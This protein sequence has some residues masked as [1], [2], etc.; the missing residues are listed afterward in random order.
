MYSPLA[1]PHAT[2]AVLDAHGLSTKYRLG[3]NFLI[4]DNVIGRILDLA[5]PQP[6]DVLLEV[7]PGIGTLTVALLSTGASVVAIECDSDLPAVLADTVPANAPFA[8]IQGDAVTVPHAAVCE[9]FGPPVALVS[10]LPYAVAA[11]VVLRYFEEFE[12]L[13]SATVMVQTEVAQRMAATP[14]SKI[15]GAYT[16]KLNL[17]AQAVSSFKVAPNSFFPPPRVSST[18]LRLERAPIVSS[19]AEYQ[20]VAHVIDAS[21]AQ[22]RKTLRNNLKQAFD[23]SSERVDA[24]CAAAGLDG[25][26][27]AETLNAQE[28]IALTEALEGALLF[29]LY[30][31]CFH[32]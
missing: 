21:F 30:P 2:R 20:R 3:Q 26:L 24:A 22:R 32:K 7:G 17:L 28:F 15:Y 23:L 13:Q 19:A 11:T 25:A 29:C 14:G 27:R 9:H 31:M 1:S 16:A 6:S 12:S 4:D 10:N 5:H 8:L 18:V